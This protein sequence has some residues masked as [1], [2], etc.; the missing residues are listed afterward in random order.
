MHAALLE[1]ARGN[2][3]AAGRTFQSAV[4][5][6]N[7]A[8]PPSPAVARNVLRAYAGFLQAAGRRPEARRVQR[9][10]EA[11]RAPDDMQDVRRYTI[12]IS[13]LRGR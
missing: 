2:G 10:A 8:S 5:A 4:A 12:D 13:E 7:E 6:S 3:A 1:A 9:E 11:F